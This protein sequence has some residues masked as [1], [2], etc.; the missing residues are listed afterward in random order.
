M[1]GNLEAILSLTPTA[2]LK[3]VHQRADPAHSGGEVRMQ[4]RCRKVRRQWPQENWPMRSAVARVF[5]FVVCTACS[6]APPAQPGRAEPGQTFSLKVGESART[7]GG[8]WEIG[9]EGVP[10]DSRCPKGEQCVWAGD[11]TVRVWLQK[12]GGARLTRELHTAPNAP[13]AGGPHIALRLV[14]LDPPALAGKSIAQRDYVATLS[15][16]RDASGEAPER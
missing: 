12:A 3:R 5:A 11:A 8:A 7:E 4:T 1:A 10:A 13:N 15:L 9:F 16:D 6:Q 14:R 2:S